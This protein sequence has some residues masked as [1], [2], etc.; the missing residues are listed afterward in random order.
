MGWVVDDA[1]RSLR[2]MATSQ[3][4]SVL[5]QSSY[6]RERC[7]AVESGTRIAMGQGHSDGDRVTRDA[8]EAIECLEAAQR[9][10]HAALTQLRQV[11][12]MTWEPEDDLD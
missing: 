12:I 7:R 10:I 6:A 2:D 1:V 11:N 3:L 5:E 4:K 9:S 8:M